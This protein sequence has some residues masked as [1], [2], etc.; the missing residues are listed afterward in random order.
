MPVAEV[1]ADRA[2]L[3]YPKVTIPVPA[4]FSQNRLVKRRTAITS[5]HPQTEI[6]PRSK[7]DARKAPGLS[8]RGADTKEVLRD[9]AWLNC[10]L[11]LARMV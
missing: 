5:C 1:L 10:V 11:L 9:W 8:P 6:V 2:A 3:T 7:S 4:T